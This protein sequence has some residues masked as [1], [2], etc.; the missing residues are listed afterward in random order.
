[1]AALS[2]RLGSSASDGEQEQASLMFCVKMQG[3]ACVG[4][5]MFLVRY[6]LLYIELDRKGSTYIGLLQHG[7]KDLL[8]LA[9]SAMTYAAS[10][11]YAPVST[12]PTG[13]SPCGCSHSSSALSKQRFDCLMLSR[14][15]SLQYR[16]RRDYAASGCPHPSTILDRQFTATAAGNDVDQLLS[17]SLT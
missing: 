13:L 4:F 2:P 16:F 14:Y 17:L 8:P 12:I 15:T 9:S 3:S 1:V 6:S 11:C 10:H 5:V 7:N